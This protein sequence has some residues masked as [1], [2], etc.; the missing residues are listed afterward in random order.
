MSAGLY[1]STSGVNRKIKKLYAN[2]GGVNREIKEL[3]GKNGGVNRKIFSGELKVSAQSY[4]YWYNDYSEGKTIGGGAVYAQGG[5][6]LNVQADEGHSCNAYNKLYFDPPI[7]YSP[8]KAILSSPSAYLMYD[9]ASDSGHS[10]SISYDGGSNDLTYLMMDEYAATTQTIAIYPS[11]YGT[12]D[13]M[14]IYVHVRGKDDNSNDHN[15][16]VQ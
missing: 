13:Y 2:V 1:G 3:W 10:A 12:T 15:D 6:T 16:R 14:K 4:G 9:D 5:F 8:G 11:T 7:D